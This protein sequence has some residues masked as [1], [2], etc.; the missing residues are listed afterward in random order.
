MPHPEYAGEP[1][2]HQVRDNPNFNLKFILIILAVMGSVLLLR[3]LMLVKLALVW[4]TMSPPFCLLLL[5]PLVEIFYQGNTQLAAKMIG[6]ATPLAWHLD[7]TP[8]AASK[9][10]PASLAKILT[11]ETM[12]TSL[13]TAGTS[14]YV[15][16]CYRLY[17]DQ[18]TVIPP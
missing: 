15:H 5:C 2:L 1:W 12:P 3:L 10:I 6:S 4:A 9:L 8:P 13:S 7:L 18:H 16:F 14:T 11:G 17:T